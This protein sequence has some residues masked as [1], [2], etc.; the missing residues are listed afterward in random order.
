MVRLWSLSTTIALPTDLETPL[1]LAIGDVNG[2]SINDIVVADPANNQILLLKND[3]LGGVASISSYSVLSG[4]TDVVLVDIDND[5]KRDIVTINQTTQ[6]VT[7]IFNTL[8]VP[9]LF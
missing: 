5:G 3:G 9:A 2:D 1:G 6:D 4:P 8:I 7:I